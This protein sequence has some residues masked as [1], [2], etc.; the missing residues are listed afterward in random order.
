MI[1]FSQYTYQN[2]LQ[3]QLNNVP[4]TLDKREGGMIYTALGP[5]SYALEDFYLVLN[6]VQQSAFI[7]TA[8][9]ESLDNL[10]VIAGVTREQATAAV[11]LGIFNIDIPIGARFSTPDGENSVNFVATQQVTTGQY[12]LTCETPGTIGNDYTGA[13]LPITVIQGLN[14]AQI[15]DI[16]IPGAD[17]ETDDS[18]RERV[19][20]QLNDTPFG[21]NIA[22]Y[23]QKITAIDGVGAVQ[24][25][26][27]WN[28]GGTVKCSILGSD[29]NPA[30]EELIETVQN[31]VDPPP[32]QGLGY[33][34]AP[35]GATVTI[36]TATELTINVSATLTLEAGYEIGQVQTPI[37]TAISSYFSEICQDWGNPITGQPTGYSQSVYVAR[38]ITAILTVT[39]VVN[40][41]NVQ[42]NSS[43]ADITLTENSTLQQ[44]P[45]LG[46]VTLSV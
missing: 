40:T 5:E 41:T 26:P 25:Y 18:L 46:A 16:L 37:E 15:T 1:D 31:T 35:I 19:I 34:T 21:G 7:Q 13:I 12:Q 22:D 24:V 38:I 6:Q 42:L 23:K 33:G 4:A 28:G 29:F 10:A 14:S 2:I 3:S 27:T 30:S 9:G 17:T 32:N 39:G 11:R 44:I 36:S 45:V 8:Q 43:T 20:S